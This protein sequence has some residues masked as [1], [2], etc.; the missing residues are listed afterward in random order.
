[1]PTSCAVRPRHVVC[2]ST[3]GGANSGNASTGMPRSSA[4]PNTIIATPAATTRNLNFRLEPTIQRIMLVC[5]PASVF[6][7]LAV[8]DAP[9]LGRPGGHDRGPDRRPL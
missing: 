1:S 3:R 6:L 8:L 2:T 5:A 7:D 4:A 9:D